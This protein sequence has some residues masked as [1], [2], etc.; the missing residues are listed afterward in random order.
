[1]A[2]IMR[3]QVSLA[4]VVGLAISAS[5]ANGQLVRSSTGAGAA[6]IQGTVD[7]FR[8]DLGVNN[9][10]GPCVGPC[11]PGTGRREV[12]WDAVPDSLASPVALPNNFFNLAAGNP[13][14]RVR[15]I[16]FS[17]GGTQLEVSA[18][19][20]SDGDGNP[21]PTATLFGN[22]HPD[23]PADFAAFS[24]E[25]IFGIL[26]SN[27]MDVTFSL[28]GDPGTPAPVRGFG[29]VFTDVELAGSTKLEFFDASNNLLHTE[30]VPAFPF[31]GADSGKSFSFLGVSFPS[32]VVSRVHITNGGF[33]V[34]LV[35][36]GPD[37]AVAMDDFIFGEPVPEP[38]TIAMGMLAAM[39]CMV[40]RRRG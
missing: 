1:M 32:P 38:G 30:N 5:Q 36:S 28:P 26:G 7:Q 15:G 20:D 18:D 16:Q 33:D 39:L 21:G 31:T 25:R 37:D 10:V 34:A 14:G 6:D 9:G 4:F 24:A 11:A 19:A 12:N 27:Q 3:V 13:A 23:N 29:A 17:T 35:Q 40:L 22:R 2:R 8:A